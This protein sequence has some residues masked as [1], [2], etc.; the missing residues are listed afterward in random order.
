MALPWRSGGWI[1]PL[2]WRIAE[3]CEIYSMSVVYEELQ[4][5]CVLR[6]SPLCCSL[7]YQPLQQHFGIFKRLL[8]QGV[9]DDIGLA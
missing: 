3:R 7:I 8:N 1:K 5:A 4:L 2:I 9:R 6:L